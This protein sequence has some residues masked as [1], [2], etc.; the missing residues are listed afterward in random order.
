MLKSGPPSVDKDGDIVNPS[1]LFPEWDDFTAEGFVSS[2]LEDTPGSFR[3]TPNYLLF[4]WG[5]LT[6]FIS[7]T[8][9]LVCTIL[10]ESSETMF[11]GNPIMM[12]PA[13]KEDE[14]VEDSFMRLATL[15]TRRMDIYVYSPGCATS[16]AWCYKCYVVRVTQEASKFP[17]LKNLDK[18]VPY[19]C[20]PLA[21][22]AKM[23]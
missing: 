5:T 14:T 1:S 19:H 3:E 2:L 9:D 10:P 21:P 23:F 17:D 20:F 13:Y 8:G 22:F 4:G 11:L 6:M 18:D 16:P 12:I 15:D 7:Q